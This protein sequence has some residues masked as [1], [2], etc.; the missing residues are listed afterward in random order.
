MSPVMDVC[1]AEASCFR[2]SGDGGGW[3]GG[4]IDLLLVRL[5]PIALLLRN[6]IVWRWVRWRGRKKKNFN[7][8]K[9]LQLNEYRFTL[10]SA[11]KKCP[12]NR[13]TMKSH[14]FLF[15][16]PPI[17]F[18]LQTCKKADR[19]ARKSTL[20]QRARPKMKR[21]FFLEKSDFTQNLN[22]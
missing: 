14:F 16:F 21:S 15:P 6:Q 1:R 7:C 17:V 20:S 18:D 2:A 11:E 8:A 9:L 19:S 22:E 3:A 4:I 10:K 12:V 13:L 5:S